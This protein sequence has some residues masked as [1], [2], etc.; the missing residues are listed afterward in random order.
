[1]SNLEIIFNGSCIN[2][3]GGGIS[4]YASELYEKINKN[5][6]YKVNFFPKKNI[7]NKI[8]IPTLRAIP[9]AYELKRKFENYNF[10]KFLKENKNIKLYHEPNFILND[11]DKKK[12]VTVHDLSW[13]HFPHFHP[14]ERVNYLEKNFEKSLK[15]ADAIIS[16][17]KFVKK[18]I[19][20]NFN[21]KPNLIKPI[22]LGCSTKFKKN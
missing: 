21:I 22:Y 18:D 20:N 1:M 2:Q 16:V 19:I 17:S 13:I 9:F 8:N 10:K 4:R 15:S 11:F 12:I 6:K 3:I 5:S 14:K 7:R